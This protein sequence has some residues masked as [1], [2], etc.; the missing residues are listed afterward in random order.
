MK[1]AQCAE[2]N[3]NT[4]FRF[5]VFGIFNHLAKKNVNPKDAQCS[6]TDF[7]VYEFFL[8]RILIFEIW[9][10][11]L[12]TFVVCVGM[13]RCETYEIF[14]NLIQK[15]LPLKPDNQLARG[16]ESLNPKAIGARGQSIPNM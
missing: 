2:T 3:G 5:L 6:E 14:T 13:Y 1:D 16:I 12:S 10:I 7:L 15:R 9:L 4:I 8:V 11:L